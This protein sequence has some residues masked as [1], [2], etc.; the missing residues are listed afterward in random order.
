MRAAARVHRHLIGYALAAVLL[1]TVAIASSMT[2]AFGVADGTTFMPCLTGTHGAAIGYSLEEF[3]QGPAIAK[4]TVGNLDAGCDGSPVLLVLSGNQAG[5]PLAPADERLTTLDSALDPCAQTARDHAPVVHGGTITLDACLSGGPAQY[6]SVHDVTQVTLRVRGHLTAVLG[7][8]IQRSPGQDTSAAATPLGDLP[9]TGS[10]AALT[11][12]IGVAAS[13]SG[14]LLIGFAR[15][16]D[17]DLDRR[18]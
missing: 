4:V 16:R 3:P 13:L 15:R 12:W 10:W 5:D 18:R 9:F 8:T 2:A 1:G 14:A 6:A 11:F 17:I 7:E